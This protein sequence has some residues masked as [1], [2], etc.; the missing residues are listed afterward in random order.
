MIEG[1]PEPRP[2]FTGSFPKVG[3]TE[4]SPLGGGPKSPAVEQQVPA[5]IAQRSRVGLL[6][7][8][9]AIGFLLG[10]GVA[11]LSFRA[12]GQAARAAAIAPNPSV[13]RL[14]GVDARVLPEVALDFGTN[15]ADST[16]RGTWARV[17]LHQYSAVQTPGPDAALEFGLIPEN[18]WYALGVLME[19]L[20][21][22]A[23]EAI[24]VEVRLNK[25]QVAR[26]RIGPTW[27][28]QAVV[29]P[30]GTLAS[31]I[32]TLEFLMPPAK[33]DARPMLALDSLHL[34]PMLSKADVA[35]GAVGVR[36]R[37]IRGYHGK[38]GEGH[39]AVTWSAGLRTRVGLL[40]SPSNTGYELALD[41]DAFGPLQ[42]L[43]VSA[44][45]NSRSIGT[46]R[47]EKGPRTVFQVPPGVLTPGLNIVEFAYPKAVR[48][49][50]TIQGSQDQRD[51]AVRISAVSVRPVTP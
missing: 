30:P 4:D 39:Q 38:E 19:A 29:L 48:P 5:K 21:I 44:V 28:M 12:P 35:V 8:G 25:R 27:D 1:P 26:W 9:G 7:T 37:L 20:A 41:G 18:K 17:Q 40:L 15:E 2:A 49:A 24:E 51:I 47:V 46:A 11:W 6:L 45:V 50:D 33:G 43:E 34:G 36:G 42:P 3:A 16:L 10:F 22:P 32:N 13:P 14:S 23:D 31:G